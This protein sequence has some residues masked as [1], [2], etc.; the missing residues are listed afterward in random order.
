ML[1]VSRGHY[2]TEPGVIY[3]CNLTAILRVKT[4]AGE[5]T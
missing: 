1:K 4:G 5:N 3:F 2:E